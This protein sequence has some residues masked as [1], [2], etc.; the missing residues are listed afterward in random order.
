[1]S[2]NQCP[3]LAEQAHNL[4]RYDNPAAW[5][6]PDM[7]DRDDW[8]LKLTADDVAEI[9]AAVQAGIVREQDLVTLRETDFLLP[10]LSS[11]L[12]EARQAILHGRG[13]VLLRGWPGTTR[14]MLENAWAFCGIGAHLGESVSQNANGHI[15]GHVTNLGMDFRDPTTRGYQTGEG[16]SFHTDAGDVVGL[17]CVRPSRS[18]GLSRIASSTTVWNEVVRQRPDLARELLQDYPHARAGEIGKGQQS[19]FH[20]P[21]FQPCGDHMVCVLIPSYIAK[22]QAFE[23][24]P[25]LRPEQKEALKFIYALASDPS[26]YLEMDFH[27]GDMQF[28]C[29]HTIL[30]SR[31]AYEDWPEL[32]RR[33]HLLRLWLACD[34]GPTLPSN[35]TTEFQGSTASGRPNGV[36]VPGIA[37]NAPLQ[38]V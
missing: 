9:D 1:M 16:L 25:R 4:P 13:F 7:T 32:E 8:I 26:N 27:P 38:P 15:L 34:D 23:D 22:A 24:V 10:G 11:R 36:L 19:T 2:I 35:I 33:R 20:V 5:Y 3:F 31:T 14:S 29:N 37:L 18:G 30:H 21:V 28:L 12:H 17:L 6:G